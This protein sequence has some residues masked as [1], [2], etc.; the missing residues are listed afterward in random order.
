M[1]FTQF[2]QQYLANNKNS[3]LTYREAM[4]DDG[5]RCAYKQFEADQ[6]K[7]GIVR[8]PEKRPEPKK[9]YNK[10]TGCGDNVINQYI[11]NNSKPSWSPPSTGAPPQPP[12]QKPGFPPPPPTAPKGSYQHDPFQQMA[13]DPYWQR[14]PALLAQARRQYE[15]AE[16]VRREAAET[17]ADP[18]PAETTADPEPAERIRVFPREETGDE[19]I[20]E[21]PE[22]DEQSQGVR[23]IENPE[24][25]Y[26]EDAPPVRREEQLLLEY[27]PSLV[28]ET[29]RE[30]VRQN[31]GVSYEQV[32]NMLRSMNVVSPR[33]I[34]QTITPGQ[35]GVPLLTYNQRDTEAPMTPP[36]LSGAT[37]VMPRAPM[38]PDA[39][40]LYRQRDAAIRRAF[41][42]PQPPHVHVR[43]T[44]A[45]LEARP[46]SEA[47]Q[48][49][50]APHPPIAN[51]MYEAR[52]RAG[53]QRRLDDFASTLDDPIEQRQMMTE[54]V[55]AIEDV[56]EAL[57]DEVAEEMKSPGSMQPGD[58]TERERA[59]GDMRKQFKAK[60]PEYI[61][62]AEHGDKYILAIP[63]AYYEELK[64]RMKK[65][66]KFKRIL[67]EKYHPLLMT[68]FNRVAR[69]AVQS[70]NDRAERKSS[71]RTRRAAPVFG[72]REYRRAINDDIRQEA[73]HYGRDRTTLPDKRR[74]RFSLDQPHEFY[75]S[76]QESYRP[77]EGTGIGMDRKDKLKGLLSAIIDVI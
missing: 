63:R 27:D 51:D 61:P 15:E 4:K 48:V 37:E 53:I 40:A 29:V 71:S 77:A 54:D 41:S 49:M 13:Q 46:L 9:R 7:K 28:A 43:D 76:V 39:E 31:P 64:K 50:P 16:R 32:L 34:P 2:V 68:I 10:D 21:E 42:L 72:S 14:N 47:E 73:F 38:P 36:P 3:G 67:E 69:D 6:C 8:K 24:V 11:D 58:I 56:A 65:E 33:S 45:P 44:E 70:R 12:S 25:M 5:V 60:G 1:K 57:I 62:D 20:V 52:R 74:K 22:E 17:T 18:E 19:P 66:R 30:E 55:R 59:R 75:H 26:I 35:A 23:F